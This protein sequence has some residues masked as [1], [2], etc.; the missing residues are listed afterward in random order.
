MA[1]PK[2]DVP[3]YDIVLPS[4]G[5]KLKI[6]PFTVK[7]EK[8]LFL[9]LESDNEDEKENATRQVVNNCIVHP[10]V[11]VDKLATYD[12]E[13]LFLQLRARSVGETLTLK[14]NPLKD[15][16]CKTC[17]AVR[18]VVVDISQVQVKKNPDHQHKIELTPKLGVIMKDPN[19]SLLKELNHIRQT[20]EI[21]DIL[22]VM[23]RCIDKLYDEKKTYDS[24]DHATKEFVEFLEN[25][26]KKQFQKI[27]EF[28]NTIPTLTHT[29]NIDCKECGLHQEYVMEG[30]K[31]FLV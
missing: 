14:F 28:F 7:E 29:V 26:P 8:I 27:D 18:E 4:T 17:S 1:L 31:D 19:F 3:L 16:T 24:K 11:D 12:I 30:L 10:E 9:A 25:L 6:R 5:E 13:Y 2:C 15:T 22:R 20:Q 23:A 21:D